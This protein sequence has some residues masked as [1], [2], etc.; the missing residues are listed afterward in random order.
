[1]QVYLS[2]ENYDDKLVN[3]FDT[4]RKRLG[5]PPLNPIN[6]G[7]VAY[8]QEFLTQG[9]GYDKTKKQYNKLDL[10]TNTTESL[11]DEAI[12]AMIRKAIASSE[13]NLLEEDL[14]IKINQ[15]LIKI[16]NG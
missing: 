8:G 10:G 15:A 3:R 6:K 13:P 14:Q 2:N 11:S 5:L 7:G 12:K 16:Q 1:M 9:I 4:Q